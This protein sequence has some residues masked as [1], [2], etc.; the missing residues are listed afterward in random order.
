[1]IDVERKVVEEVEEFKMEIKLLSKKEDGTSKFLITNTSFQILNMYRRL[2]VNKVPTMAVDTVE[3]NENSSALYDDMLAHRLGLLA[4]KTDLDVCFMKDNKK[5]SVTLALEAE[6]PCTVYAE[7]MEPSDPG[8]YPIH[9]KTPIVKLLENQ[10]LK[11]IATA[12]TGNGKEHIKHSPALMF[13]QKYPYLKVK[14]EKKAEAIIKS[15]PIDSNKL[16]KTKI[17]NINTYELCPGCLGSLE[18]ENHIETKDT[19]FLV[20]I[21]PWGQLTTGEIIEAVATV[22]NNLLDELATE[23]KKIK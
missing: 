5:Y 13:Y 20:T 17:K 1:M 2:I 10:R 8:V 12:T 3:I 22:S 23:I 21:E 18:D 9:K 6:G 11:F 7:Q 16:E 4:L 15:C 19:D 14:D